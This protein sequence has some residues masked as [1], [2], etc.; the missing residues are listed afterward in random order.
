MKP[1]RHLSWIEISRSALFRNISAL[2]R[3]AG[4]RIMA[5]CVKANAY[6]HGLPQI[7]GLIA[8][9]PRVEYLTVHSLEE[10]V[11]CRES[12]WV[13]KIMVLGPIATQN[14]EAV[15]EYDLEPVVFT[16][17]MLTRLGKISDR[18]KKRI[19]THLKL[20]TGTN[21]Q[22][23]TEGELP[24]FA[25][26]YRKYPYLKRPWGAGMHFANIEDTTSHE[27]AEYQLK[28]YRRLVAAM[29]RMGIKP[30]LRHTACSAA[31][32]LFEKTRFDLVRPGIAVYGHWPSK[33]TYLTYRLQGGQNDIVNPVLS[34]KTRITQIKRLPANSFIGYGCSYRTTSPTRLAVLPIGYY[35]GYDRSL[36]NQA[37][38]LIRGK[39]SPVR[40]R[41]CMNLMM[42]DVTDIAGVKLGDV[43][44]L[45][46]RDGKEVLTAEQ[47][48]EWAQT[49]NYEIL[50]RLSPSIFR[51]L[52]H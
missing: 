46:G 2:G 43:A 15:L 30:T 40:G 11:A 35:D 16:R 52:A 49:I 18:T 21:R 20:E 19:R 34:W 32:M 12:G 25:A 48:A 37:Y 33:E 14:L 23:I 3:M 42:V 28:N 44:T 8:K 27:Y 9:H 39:R 29:G 17:E 31:L 45:V 4:N 38:V 10:A 7:V 41:V 47:L 1:S 13:R 50:A 22:G 5:V 26:I 51:E 24:A 36:S 6:G